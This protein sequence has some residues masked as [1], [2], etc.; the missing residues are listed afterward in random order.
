M[1]ARASV[2]EKCGT[3]EGEEAG[4]RDGDSEGAAC[5][6]EEDLDDEDDEAEEA[7]EEVAVLVCLASVSLGFS[8]ACERGSGEGWGDREDSGNGSAE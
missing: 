7:E 1:A 4:E 2:T 5:L 3:E 6:L 8:G